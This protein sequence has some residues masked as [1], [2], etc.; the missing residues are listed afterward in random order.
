[1]WEAIIIQHGEADNPP[2]PEAEK[3]MR[4]PITIRLLED[5]AEFSAAE[6]VQ[7]AA[8]RMPDDAEMVPGHLLRA[9]Q[10]HGGVV[11]GAFTSGGE[12]VGMTFGFVGLTDDQTQIDQLG[13][14]TLLYSHML[15][16][17]PAYQGRSIGYRLKL[18]QRE[19]ALEQGHRLIIWTFD[20]L[21]SANARLNVGKLGGICRHYLPDAYGELKEGVNIGLPSDRFDLEWWIA[22]KHAAT[23][24]EHPPL[25][26]PLSAWRAAGAQLINPSAPRPDG[27]RAPGERIDP[28]DSDT[29][30][31]EIPGSVAAL[32][33]ADLGLARAWRFHTRE[34]IQ[35][36]FEAG[37]YVADVTAEGAGQT[38]RSF[39]LLKH[40]PGCRGFF[41]E[42]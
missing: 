42:A 14:S 17:L 33:A 10:R 2:A 35:A 1:L 34:V 24:L 18:A 30:L 8:W 15:G 38:R 21:Q 5:Q 32:K 31:V 27:L 26:S 9:A 3:G 37:Y 41:E 13:G 23:R 29:I 36:A 19:H 4:D 20:P 39:Y 6:D 7:R 11:L 28:P 22:S 16:V 12:M 25:P 40:D